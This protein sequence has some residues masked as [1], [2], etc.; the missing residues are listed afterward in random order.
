MK[1]SEIIDKNHIIVIDKTLKKNELI[2]TLTNKLCELDSL[3]DF[4]SIYSQLL[5]R[6]KLGSTA[7]GNG[8][9]IPHIRMANIDKPHI[10]IGNVKADVDFVTN[11]KEPVRVVFLLLTPDGDVA[12]HLN[13]LA[14]I[15]HIVKNTDFV[16]RAINATNCDEIYSLLIEE[17]SKL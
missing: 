7:I 15:S 4:A 13:L 1:L 2:K 10:L 11:D 12:T 17:E 5:E 14:H 6:E 8:A 9:A 16:K 3:N